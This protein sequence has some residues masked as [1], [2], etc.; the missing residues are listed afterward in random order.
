MAHMKD[1]PRPMF[2][3]SSYN[4]EASSGYKINSI[5]WLWMVICKRLKKTYITA[6]EAQ[7]LHCSVDVSKVQDDNWRS[8]NL[9]FFCCG[10]F[11][12]LFTLI[13]KLLAIIQYSGDRLKPKTIWQYAK[14][15]IMCHT[16]SNIKNIYKHES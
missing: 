7:R 15:T 8:I 4:M 2:N 3:T 9:I 16:S 1:P 11:W 10:N 14:G 5:E 13:N 6:E 12:S